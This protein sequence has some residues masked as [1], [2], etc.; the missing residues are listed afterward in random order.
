[1]SSVTAVKRPTFA[2]GVAAAF[3][4]ALAGS[5]LF[6]GAIL[7]V[8]PATALTL[9]I[10]MVVGAYVLY[11][12]RHAPDRTGRVAVFALWAACAL[13]LGLC[14]ASW[15]LTIAAHAVLVWLVRALYFHA[16]VLPVLADLA[17][18]VL[19]LAGGAWAAT[20]TGSPFLALWTFFLVHALFVAIP[21]SLGSSVPAARGHDDASPEPFQQARRAA[22]AALRR[23]SVSR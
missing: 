4:I 18:G 6:A 3:V 16:G 11:L 22:E 17:L 21:Q 12:L 15:A 2:R 10:P 19:A 8:T 14:G 13:A 9:L 23:L 7:V 20:Q 1:M 5:A